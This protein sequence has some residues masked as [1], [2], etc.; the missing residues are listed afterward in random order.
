MI[1]KRR[2]KIAKDFLSESG[3]V[4]NEQYPDPLL[5]LIMKPVWSAYQFDKLKY[6]SLISK[7]SL[8]R[9]LINFGITPATIEEKIQYNGIVYPSYID[10]EKQYHELERNNPKIL[11][12]LTH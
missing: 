2:F 3:Y 11:D 7:K 6:G 9:I 5:H 8:L 4:E 10:I 12:F 1:S